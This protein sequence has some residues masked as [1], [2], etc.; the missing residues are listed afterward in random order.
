MWVTVTLY[1]CTLLPW[2]A[3]HKSPSAVPLPVARTATPSLA[4]IVGAARH[5]EGVG[6][7][8]RFGTAVTTSAS[9]ST[10]AIAAVRPAPNLKV[11]RPTPTR[12]A[13][14][15]TMLSS[16]PTASGKG[17]VRVCDA[18][19]KPKRG[20]E[21]SNDLLGLPW[22]YGANGEGS[23]SKKRRRA[24]DASAES[25]EV[26]KRKTAMLHRDDGEGS[27]GCKKGALDIDP[28]PN[29]GVHPDGRMDGSVP[30]PKP[31]MV[32]KQMADKFN[33]RPEA[34]NSEASARQVAQAQV[35]YIF[36]IGA[37]FECH[38]LSIS[39]PVTV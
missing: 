6:G 12:A 37:C 20:R 3:G 2:P 27:C 31:S 11:L 30:V 38:F 1:I 22:V 26:T 34:R 21:K 15:T 36:T 35:L 28:M 39:V 32:Y 7:G 18:A 19:G 17:N 25:G 5:R 13:G 29:S 4:G 10:R 24:G 23:D 33:I 14:R 8:A 16:I 9:T